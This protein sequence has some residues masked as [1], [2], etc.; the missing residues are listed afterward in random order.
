[1]DEAFGEREEGRGYGDV[2]CSCCS[3]WLAAGCGCQFCLIFLH[4]TFYV[5]VAVTHGLVDTEHMHAIYLIM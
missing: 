5:W 1:M 4:R 2:P 3:E